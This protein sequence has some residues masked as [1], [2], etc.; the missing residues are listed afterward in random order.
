MQEIVEITVDS[1]AAKS[2]W[3]IRKRQCFEDK[4]GEDDEIGGSICQSDPCGRRCESGIG[5]KCNMKFFDAD[6]KK[7]SWFLRVRLSTRVTSS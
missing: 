3:P 2:V 1:G 5:K 7:E 4:G 6:V